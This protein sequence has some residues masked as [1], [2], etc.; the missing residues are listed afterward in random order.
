[1]LI[2]CQSLVLAAGSWPFLPLENVNTSY[3]SEFQQI[4]SINVVGEHIFKKQCQNFTFQKLPN[5]L[6]SFLTILTEIFILQI[7]S[8][9]SE[10]R[11][12][13]K[14]GDAEFLP[15]T[16]AGNRRSTD[17]PSREC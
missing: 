16:G 17:F 9:W 1:M 10:M 8:K 2:F 3:H 4:L 13:H 7:D 14:I 5:I 11:K 12:K 15:V 6:L